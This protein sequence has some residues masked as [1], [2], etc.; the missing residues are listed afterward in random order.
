[1]SDSDLRRLF[2]GLL[3]I[4]LLI[5]GGLQTWY[6]GNAEDWGR[7]FFLRGGLV[8]GV[9]WIAWPALQ[10]PARWIPPG[11]MVGFLLGLVLIVARPKLAVVL[12]PLAIA[13]TTVAGTLRWLRKS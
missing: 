8:L 2:A 1:M 3:S 11:M 5:I 7:S 13:I 9:L 12:V 4:F 6:L 10:K